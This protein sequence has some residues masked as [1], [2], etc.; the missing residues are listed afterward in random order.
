MA[1]P[2]V[3]FRSPWRGAPPPPVTASAPPWR[4]PRPRRRSVPQ[5][6]VQAVGH[7]PRCRP[8]RVILAVRVDKED[9]RG[10]LDKRPVRL[11]AGKGAL[12]GALRSR[13]PA[14]AAR[15]H[16]RSQ[17]VARTPGDH[18]PSRPRG[19]AE[20][21]RARAGGEGRTHKEKMQMKSTGQ[22]SRKG[23][24]VRLPGQAPADVHCTGA[25]WLLGRRCPSAQATRAATPAMPPQTPLPPPAQR[26]MFRLNAAHWEATE[27]VMVRGWKEHGTTQKAALPAARRPHTGTPLRRRWRRQQQQRQ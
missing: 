23:E 8:R 13:R 20:N 3:K 6:H 15:R 7:P 4:C 22:Q 17:T 5:H 19:P 10:A 2:A 12:P 24:G 27:S 16:S 1:H 21:D 11:V 9:R 14:A 25:P 26:T 18:H